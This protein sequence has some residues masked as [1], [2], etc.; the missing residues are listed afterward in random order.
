MYAEIDNLIN[1]IEFKSLISKY[2]KPNCF[3]I[4][5]N[6]RREEWHSNVVC[7]ILNPKSNHGLGSYPLTLFFQLLEQKSNDKYNVEE[8]EI[9]KLEFST[10]HPIIKGRFDI[11]A[12]N[13]KM[14]LIIENKVGSAEN[15]NEKEGKYQT[16]VYYDYVER[17]MKDKKQRCYVY[18]S[19]ISN[20]RAHNNHFECI[21]YQEL[22]DSVIFNCINLKKIKDETRYV[23][24]QYAL[25]LSGHSNHMAYTEKIKANEIYQKHKNAFDRIHSM[26]NEIDRDEETE[27]MYQKYGRYFNEILGAIGK[28][29]ISPRT[30]KMPRGKDLIKQLCDDEIV[31]PEKTELIATRSSLHFNYIIQVY[32]VNGEYKCCVGCFVGDRYKGEKVDALLNEENDICYFDCIDQAARAVEE[33][34]YGEIKRKLPNGYGV[35]AGDWKLRFAGKDSMEGKYIKDIYSIN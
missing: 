29:I 21:T 1:D 4:M 24:E 3:N 10:E 6:T 15:R 11:F 35:P 13:E 23:L 27:K 19:P 33:K 17:N 9:P 26:M 20:N 32:I 31:I 18:L 5:G 34:F 16:D 7:W 14:V 30:E 12:E 2:E 25:S 28:P 8:F 22:F